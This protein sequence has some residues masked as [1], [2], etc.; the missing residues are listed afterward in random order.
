[1]QR[2]H[3]TAL[4]LLAAIL[5]AGLL[6]LQ[7]VSIAPELGKPFSIVVSLLVG[8]LALFELRLW[9]IGW[10]QGWFVKRPY[11]G[12]TWSVSVTSDWVDPATNRS[13]EPFDAYLVVRQTYTTLSLR[14]VTQES[15]S[16][17]LGADLSSHP[18]G[19]FILTG[20]YRNEPALS[21]RDRSPIHHG[22]LLLNVRGIPPQA[23]DGLYWTDRGTKGEIRSTAHI[24]KLCNGFA[25]AQESFAE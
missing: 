5:W 24:T 14:L 3:V 4:L 19:V 6:F 15:Q 16:Y 18:D 22:A 11:L 23:L 13:L 20:V 7:G 9:R 17:V 21:V 10:L 8:G 25:Q 2:I 1:M 12:G